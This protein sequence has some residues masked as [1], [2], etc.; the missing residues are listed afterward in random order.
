MAGLIQIQVVVQG[1]AGVVGLDTQGRVW[2]GELSGARSPH[3]TPSSGQGSRNVRSPIRRRPSRCVACDT[4]RDR[5][6]GTETG[7][8]LRKDQCGS[9]RGV[10]SLYSASDNSR[11]AMFNSAWVPRGHQFDLVDV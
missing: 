9:S 3:A 4:G 7:P 11:T 5:L 1:N 6:T 8:S 10:N 2:Y